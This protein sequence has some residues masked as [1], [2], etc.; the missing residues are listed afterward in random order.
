MKVDRLPILTSSYSIDQL[1]AVSKLITGTTY[2]WNLKEN[3]K[4]FVFDTTAFN[5]G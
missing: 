2:D 5:T 1:L 4:A 3:F